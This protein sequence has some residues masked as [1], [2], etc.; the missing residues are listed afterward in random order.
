MRKA[1]NTETVD[2]TVTTRCAI[3]TRKSHEEG[4]EQDFNSLDAQR[5][6]CEAYILSQK[7]EGWT[8]LPEMYD[9]GGISGATLGRPA[10]KRILEDIEAGGIDAVVVYKVDRLTR[11]LGD[12]AKIVEIFDKCQVSFVSVTQQFNTTTSMGRLTLNMLLSF[13]QFEREVTGERIR[14]KIAASK[15]KGMWMGGNVPLGYDVKDRKLVVNEAEAGTVRHIYRRYAV[16]GTV[17]GLKDELDRDGIVSKF[18]VDRFGR[19]KGG[20]PLAR[21][22]LYLMLRNR[23]YLGEIVHKENSYPGEHEAI[24]DE[25]LWDKVHRKLTENRVDRANGSDAARPSLLAGLIY[26]D[27]GE[28]MIPSHANKKGTRYHYYVSQTLIKGSRRNATRGR[29]VPAGDLE[30]LVEDRL[31]EFLTSET[32]VFAAIETLLGDVNDRAE[33]ITSAGNLALRWSALAPAERRAILSA[34]VDRV[35][36]LRETLEIRILPGRLPSILD[37]GWQPHERLDP[38]ENEPTITFTVP[39]R[40][41]RTGMETRLLIDGAGGGARKKPDHSLHR[42]LAQAHKYH[43]MVMRNGGNTMAEL[44]AEA[45]AGGS[46]FTRILRLGFL[47][48]DVVKAILR[49]RHPVELTAKR[50]VSEVL[51][52]IAWKDQHALLGTG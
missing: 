30:A 38:K 1:K 24:I 51:L 43:A 12:F 15:K 7:H 32:G 34:L 16:L 47:A 19:T 29:R 49:D 20:A 10:L 27:S 31:R 18:R 28:R 45:G 4:L 5:E 41:K 13:A 22:A 42:V 37:D 40:L 6:A 3:Y 35:D 52:P 36:L 2:R 50:L 8:C 46:Y 14:D 25:P 11:T 26:D 9:D 48:P 39:A 33:V 21:G 44:A 23:I 17:A